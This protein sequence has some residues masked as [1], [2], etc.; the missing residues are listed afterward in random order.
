MSYSMCP[1]RQLSRLP[2]A[3]PRRMFSASSMLAAAEVKRLG[4]VGAG[5][6]VRLVLNIQRSCQEDRR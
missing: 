3:V 4:V 6:M 5:Q 1:V 2:H